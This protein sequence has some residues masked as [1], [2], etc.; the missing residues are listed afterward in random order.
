MGDNVTTRPK[1]LTP[2]EQEIFVA[3]IKAYPD[4][5]AFVHTTNDFDKIVSYFKL[6]NLNK[7]KNFLPFLKGSLTTSIDHDTKN[8]I[9]AYTQTMIHEI[10]REKTQRDEEE[11]RKEE[12]AQ[13]RDAVVPRGAMYI[14]R[15]LAYSSPGMQMQEQREASRREAREASRREHDT[16]VSA[17]RDEPTGYISSRDRDSDGGA[18]RRKSKRS[19]SRRRK[20]KRN[21]KTHR[22]KH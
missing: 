20:S 7:A 14:P 2:T 5:V 15:N 4:S 9:L 16:T 18:R 12:E 19:K 22:N 13:G 3:K 8:N 10:E 6:S 1:S 11:R 17:R 21:K